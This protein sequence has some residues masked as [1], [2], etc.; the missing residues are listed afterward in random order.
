[1]IDKG[2][3]LNVKDNNGQTPIFHACYYSTSEI[4]K[5]IIDKGAD[6][7]VKDNANISLLQLSCIYCEF[8]IIMIFMILTKKSYLK[9]IDNLL[10]LNQKLDLMNTHLLI[11]M[12]KE[13]V[14]LKSICVISKLKCEMAKHETFDSEHQISDSEHQISDSE[15]ETSNTKLTPR[16]MKNMK[17]LI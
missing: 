5:Y 16:K 3:D 14:K 9:P 17:H 15:H 12:Y 11:R 13:Q 7:N 10:N 1:M 2:V 6:L 8:E 4:I